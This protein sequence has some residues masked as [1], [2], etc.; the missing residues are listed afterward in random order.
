MGTRGLARG[1][2]FAERR[3]GT[4]LLALATLAAV[5]LSLVAGAQA[6]QAPRALD[7]HAAVL[8]GRIVGSAFLIEPD[9]ALT[10]AHVVEGLRLGATVTLVSGG[11]R[12]SASA[13]VIAVSQRMDLALLRPPAGFL[14][15]VSVENAPR[16]A[17][18]SV[19]GAGVDASGRPGLG[20]RLELGGMVIAPETDLG[21]YGPG[22][23]VAMPGV[24]PGFSGGPVLDAEGRL[25][26]MI[27]A[28]RASAAPQSASSRAP[29]RAPERTRAPDE[30][31]VLRAAEIRREAVRLLRTARN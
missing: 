18:L 4:A 19:L 29:T 11:R 12:T 5:A 24:K 14:P 27:T 13:R 7:H 31:F 2:G 17:G 16:R 20:P 22:L 21:A 15:A 28:I 3:R 25:V 8:N 30:A 6:K 1:A 26:G 23:V 10:N 9:L